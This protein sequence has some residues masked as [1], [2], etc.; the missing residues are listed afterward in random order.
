VA[1]WV[2]V[3]AYR[4]FYDVPH[5][6]VTR[7]GARLLLFESRFDESLD[8]YEPDY[9]VY[10]LRPTDGLPDGSWEHL[11]EGLTR[12]G[13]VS[14]REVEFGHDSEGRYALRS[15]ELGALEQVGD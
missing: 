7:V 2:P 4:E 11:S 6:L 8:D 14:L 1:G 5:L 3:I 10:E 9:S 15:A 13:A 12:V